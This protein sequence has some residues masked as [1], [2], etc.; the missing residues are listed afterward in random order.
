MAARA[1]APEPERRLLRVSTSLP[2]RRVDELTC[3]HAP[4]PHMVGD[5][6]REEA[7]D[8]HYGICRQ[9]CDA[10][11]QIA[12]VQ[13]VDVCDISGQGDISWFIDCR[14]LNRSRAG[15]GG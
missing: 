2:R 10:Q 11:L 3:D 9:V 4:G 15:D 5:A 14:L 6:D 1:P 13:I 7:N 8:I 12:G